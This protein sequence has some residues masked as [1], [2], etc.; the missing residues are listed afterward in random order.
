[1]CDRSYTEVEKSGDKDKLPPL[2]REKHNIQ[3]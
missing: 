3:T 1:M 2:T